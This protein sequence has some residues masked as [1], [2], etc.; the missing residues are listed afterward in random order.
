MRLKLHQYLLVMI[1]S[2]GIASFSC[3]RST[4][5]AGRD[6]TLTPRQVLSMDDQNF[7]L[8]AQKVAIRQKALAQGALA[9]SQ[10]A[11]VV[12]FARRIVRE[13]D[14]DLARLTSL[15]NAKNMNPQPALMQETQLEAANRLSRLNDGALDH[16]F[17][18][19]LAAEEQDVVRQFDRAVYTAADL[20]VRS[21]AAAVLPSLRQD[22]EMAAGLEKNL[23]GNANS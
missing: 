4:V 15:L 7:L 18:S 12:E 16:E 19:L 21:Y 14:V 5:E 2:A 11:D 8:N 9:K 17:V 20:D 22:L 3:G 1:T 13:R 10:N 6:T 23:T